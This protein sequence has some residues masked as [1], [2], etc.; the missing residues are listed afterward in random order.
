M[1]NC[2]LRNNGTA[3]ESNRRSNRRAIAFRLLRWNGRRWNQIASVRFERWRL[4]AVPGLVPDDVFFGHLAERRF[5]VTNFIRRADQLDYLQEPDVFHDLFGH[6]PLLMDPVFAD[7][8]QAYG[9]GGL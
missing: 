5:P 9:R 3:V 2:D 1:G 8:L 6:V 4:V 7:D